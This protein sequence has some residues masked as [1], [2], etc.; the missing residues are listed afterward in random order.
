MANDIDG[1]F[2]TVLSAATSAASE[3][4]QYKNAFID[5]IYWDYQAE[6]QA[7]QGA[8]IDVILPTVDEGDVVDSQGGA[9]TPTDTKHSKATITLDRDFTTSFLIRSF[10]QVR[11]RIEL[12]TKFFKPRLEA[13]LR[14]MN[15]G[16]AELVTATNF[17]TY[18]VI[19]GS[20][21]DVFARADLGGAWKNLAGRGVPV[22]SEMDMSFITS[23]VAYGN[24]LSDSNFA[25]ESVVGVNAS[26][27]AFQQAKLMNLLGARPYYDQHLA[28]FNSGKEPGILMHRGAIAGVTVNP[29]SGADY[30]AIVFPKPGLPVLVEVGYS[31][32]DRGWL[33][34]MTAQWGCRVVRPEFGSLVETA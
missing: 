31:I 32:K 5:A 17:S 22:E 27:A 16:V 34:G 13:L 7:A 2:A 28:R 3:I 20:G 24:M 25:D 4:T 9:Y 11:T 15:R 21:A 14:K 29:L 18:S 6:L 19:S 33:V 8:A 30:K 12:Q 26:Q 10:D 23:P 1:L